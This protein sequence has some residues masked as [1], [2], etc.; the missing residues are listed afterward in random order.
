VVWRA[1]FAF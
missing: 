1:V